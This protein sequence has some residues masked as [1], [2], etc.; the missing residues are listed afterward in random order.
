M[1]VTEHPPAA[2]DPSELG[3]DDHVQPWSR[4]FVV[5]FLFVFVVCGVVGVEAWPLTGWRLFSHARGPHQVSWQAVA[6]EGSSRHVVVFSRL[7]WA[8]HGFSLVMDRFDR[9][10]ASRRAETCQAWRTAERRHDGRTVT[11]LQLFRVERDL[12][13]PAEPGSRTLVFRCPAGGALG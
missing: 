11:A 9:L 6:V 12:R 1:A 10:S 2:L 3:S 4:R 8:F 13:T 7:P 5:A